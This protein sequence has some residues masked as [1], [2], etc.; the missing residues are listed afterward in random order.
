MEEPGSGLNQQPKWADKAATAVYYDVCPRTITNWK[1][2]D[3]LVFFQIGRVVRFDLVASD[4]RLKEFGI[5]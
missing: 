4:T 5:N 1:E 3:Y 2:R